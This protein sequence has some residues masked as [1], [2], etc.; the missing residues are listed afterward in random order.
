MGQASTQEKKVPR[1]LLRAF[2]ILKKKNI[3]PLR[4]QKAKR[5]EWGK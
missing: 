4:Y 1:S 5:A 2:G 3:N